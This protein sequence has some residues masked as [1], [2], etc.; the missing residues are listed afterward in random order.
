MKGTAVTIPMVL[1]MAAVV[2]PAEGCR[3]Q[4]PPSEDVILYY[5]RKARVEGKVRR[6]WPAG[7]AYVDA[8]LKADAKLQRQ[9]DPLRELCSTLSLWRPE[10]PRWRE[11]KP[12]AQRMT[13]ISELVEGGERNRAML[14]EQ[15]AEAV[16]QVPD[17]LGLES[18]EAKNAFVARVW[19]ALVLG[20]L[21]LRTGQA[22]EPLEAVGSAYL[23]L[24][25]AVQ[26]CADDFDPGNSGLSFRTVAC[27]QTVDRQYGALQQNLEAGREGFVRYA[28]QQLMEL[29]PRLAGI[30]KAER[31]EEY[32][33]L[34]D[35]RDYFRRRLEAIPKRLLETL[36]ATENELK[37]LER[38]AS[39]AEAGDKNAIDVRI[40]FSKRFVGDLK[41]E[42]E[43]WQSRVQSILERVKQATERE[44]QG[45]QQ[46]G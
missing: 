11:K 38:D 21:D 46:D 5:L 1:C 3:P 42:Q 7:Q 25:R 13:S 37:G 30:D 8:V 16:D 44:P 22:V 41:Q 29:A 6:A 14:L 45:S 43:T 17:G 27:R 15:L 33:Y 10:D 19:E 4:Q 28:E 31:R 20:R 24:F 40:A 18:A 12:C 9:L 2:G 32:E 34:S 35:R 39:K 36:R 26:D 23:Q